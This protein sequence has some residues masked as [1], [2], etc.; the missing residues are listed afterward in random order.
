MLGRAG[1]D[2]VARKYQEMGWALLDRN[3]RV[4][5]GELDLVF[6]RD[7]VRVFCEVKTRRST[8]FGT[9]AE[10]V[11]SLKQARIRRLAVLWLS[12]QTGNTAP[13]TELRFDVASVVVGEGGV[14]TLDIIEAAF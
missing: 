7:H 14:A 6:G 11:T 10:A 3:W 2:L 12:T 4:R 9:P 13:I 5:A 8:A 1:E